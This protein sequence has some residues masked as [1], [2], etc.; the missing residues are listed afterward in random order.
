MEPKMYNI[1]QDGYNMEV[2]VRK[3]AMGPYLGHRYQNFQHARG[4]PELRG[5]V[6]TGD[7]RYRF[8]RCI[9]CDIRLSLSP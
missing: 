2:V 4:N 8:R 3:K 5:V 6:P 1:I 9:G 7:P